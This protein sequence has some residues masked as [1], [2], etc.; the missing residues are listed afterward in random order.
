VTSSTLK[1]QPLHKM[2][3]RAFRITQ[4]VKE[5]TIEMRWQ[6]HAPCGS[7]M[8]GVYRNA[9]MS[10]VKGFTELT[11]EEMWTT[12]T[13]HK[14]VTITAKV[15]DAFNFM[16]MPAHILGAPAIFTVYWLCLHFAIIRSLPLLMSVSI[17]RDRISKLQ[18]WKMY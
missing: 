14:N 16:N 6:G 11:Q 1:N 2:I 3:S 5:L 15:G 17:K 4:A 12:D 9:D 13:S 8:I 10:T 18:Y 7:K